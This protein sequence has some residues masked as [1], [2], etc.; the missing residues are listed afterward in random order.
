MHRDRLRRGWAIG[1]GMAVIMGCSA[2][3]TVA[4]PVALGQATGKA[5]EATDKELE[6][7]ARKVREGRNDEALG[8]IREQAAQH[9]EWPPAPLILARLLFAAGQAV[10][11]RRALEQ[12][13]IEAP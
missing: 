8:L 13:A 10:P 4:G 3:A 5:V 11:G 1:F 2:A 9:P 6:A 7:A 12:A